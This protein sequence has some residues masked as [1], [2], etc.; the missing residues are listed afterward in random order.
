[1]VE[2]GS[3]GGGNAAAGLAA[4]LGITA[5]L[6]VQEIG[7]DTDTDDLV[8][9]AV[10]LG[11]GEEP[12]DEDFDGVVDVVLL[13]WRDEDGDLADALVD[14]KAPL[15]GSGVIWLFTPK[16]GRRGDVEPADIV[17]ACSTSGLRRTTS[18]SLAQWQ[19]LRLVSR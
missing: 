4:R 5:G 1:M 6:T 18:A 17:D 3:E 11:S 2:G 7:Y 15:A 9:D 13:W 10:R 14:A 8:I 12:V 19:G 16:H